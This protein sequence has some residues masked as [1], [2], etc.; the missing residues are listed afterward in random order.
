MVL[1][2]VNGGESGIT[3]DWLPGLFLVIVVVCVWG[4]W[5]RRTQARKGQQDAPAE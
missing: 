2:Q 3:T 4:I 5:H 1:L